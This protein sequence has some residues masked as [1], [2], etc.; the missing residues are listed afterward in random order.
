[1][2]VNDYNN[3]PN[4]KFTFVQKDQILKDQKFDT[5]PVSY[6][7]DAW[8]RFCRNKGSVI[9]AI[10][11]LFLVLYAIFIPIF[12]KHSAADKDAY[13]TYLLPKN[14]FL[15]QFGIMQGYKDYTYNQQTFDYYNSMPGCIV[16]INSSYEVEDAGRKNTF[17][18]VTVD[19]YKQVGY[20]YKLLTPEEYQK[21]L[22]YEQQTGIKLL[23]PMINTKE[24][25]L[26]ANKSDPNYWFK[27]N[28]KS[29]ATYDKSGEYQNIFMKDKENPDEYVYYTTKMQGEQLQVRVLYYDWYVYERGYEPCYLFGTDMYGQDILSRLAYGAR[30]SLLLA[31]AV[32]AINL[33][34]GTIFGA[35][36]GYYGGTIDLVLERVID[37]LHG[38]PFI[39]LATL[40]QMYLMSK[41]GVL[42]ALLFAF[43][44]T[45]WIGPAATVR[46]QFYR[47]KGQEYVLA[48]RTLGA[49]DR[50]IIFRHI[51]PNALGTIITA[52]VLIIPGV[53]FSESSLAYLGI[54]DLQSSTLTSIG[55]MLSNGQSAL[56]RFPHAI[57]LPALFI[58]LLMISFNLFGNGLRDAF[59]PSLRGSED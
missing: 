21:I 28:Q 37:I 57:F 58:S 4:E 14:N 17:Y 59:N 41:V 20:I 34:I 46:S 24:I 27:H 23:A 31:V 10:I 1:M 40:F 49:K 44:F 35:I 53:I 32:S 43:V 50:R 22:D 18:N 12:S 29:Y 42:G 47:Y 33:C 26:D 2:N 36:E 11:I 6:L 15:S 30:L 25:Q 45:G 52:C 13:Y 5:K 3:I 9:A 7:R 8:N 51:L 16:R 19:T 39:V 56:F 55:T 38:I 48:A 54:V